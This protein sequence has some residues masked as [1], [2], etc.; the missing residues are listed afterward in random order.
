VS[1]DPSYWNRV[2]GTLSDFG[3]P[4]ILASESVFGEILM[5]FDACMRG[6][7]GDEPKVVMDGAREDPKDHYHGAYRYIR[8]LL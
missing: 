5:V 3:D 1:D 6:A 7:I 4:Y 2:V 8:I